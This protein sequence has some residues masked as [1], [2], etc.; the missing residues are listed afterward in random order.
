M[1]QQEAITTCRMAHATEGARWPAPLIAYLD[2]PANGGR[3]F[4]WVCCCVAE[5][6]ESYGRATPEIA[7]ASSLAR[8]Q[9]AEGNDFEALER[10]AWSFWSRRSMEE[11]VFTAIGQLLFALS[12]ADRCDRELFALACAT[13]ILL[14]EQ[15]ESGSG[16]VLD[17]V[18]SHFSSYVA[19]REAGI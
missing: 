8:R 11:P 5:V 6:L 17:R 3:G 10:T 19:Q 13:P 4:D 16:V 7:E 2:D 14:L 12:R 18:T 9:A 15:L 1:T